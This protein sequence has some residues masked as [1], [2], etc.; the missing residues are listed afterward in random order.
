MSRQFEIL[1]TR[2]KGWRFRSRLE[3]RW[4][5]YFDDLGIAFQYETISYVMDGLC[6]LPD[7]WL[8]QVGLWAEVKPR[9]F[10]AMELLKIDR[11]VRGTGDAAIL[12]IG[13]PDFNSYSTI[14]LAEHAGIPELIWSDVLISNYHSYPRDEHRF[15]ACTEFAGDGQGPFKIPD[16]CDWARDEIAHAIQASRSARFEYDDRYIETPKP[17]RGRKTA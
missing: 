8:P 3:A 15:Y 2:W 10:D 1:E 13:P 12:L 5:V 4:A 6:Y 17:K 14:E 11:L 16:D 9:P 7:F